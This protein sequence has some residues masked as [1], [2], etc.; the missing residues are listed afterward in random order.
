MVLVYVIFG[1]A[2]AAGGKEEAFRHSA[3][4]AGPASSAAATSSNSCRT[5]LTP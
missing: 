1:E 2:S 4:R 3:I 5:T